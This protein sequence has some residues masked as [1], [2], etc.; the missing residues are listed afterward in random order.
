MVVNF[1]FH[2]GNTGETGAE[3]KQ[4]QVKVRANVA[5]TAERKSV[6]FSLIGASVSYHLGVTV[7]GSVLL[8]L[9]ILWFFVMFILSRLPNFC[10]FAERMGWWPFTEE[11]KTARTNL[12]EASKVVADTAGDVYN[13]MEKGEYIH[14]V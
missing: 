2:R 6:V 4:R 13:K 8:A 1:V 14:T 3:R 10:G 7:V 9:G 12:D 11:I 5:Q